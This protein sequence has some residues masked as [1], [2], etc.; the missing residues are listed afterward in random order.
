MIGFRDSIKRWKGKFF[1]VKLTELGDWAAGM[2]W[3]ESTKMTDHKPAATEYDEGSI[4]RI[5]SLMLDIRKLKE[6]V[7]HAAALSPMPIERAG[8]LMDKGQCRCA[9]EIKIIVMSGWLK[10]ANI[11]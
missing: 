8:Q 7:L 1:F 3:R 10:M 9:V 4:G 11:N 6:P 2:R 5:S